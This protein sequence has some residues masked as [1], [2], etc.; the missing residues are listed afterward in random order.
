[1]KKFEEVFDYVPE[2]D[3][4]VRRDGEDKMT[5][6]VFMTKDIAEECFD[7]EVDAWTDFMDGWFCYILHEKGIDDFARYCAEEGFY[8]R[9]NLGIYKDKEYEDAVDEWDERY[10]KR[11]YLKDRVSFEE[12]FK[13]VYDTVFE[14]CA[15]DEEL[16]TIAGID[17][18]GDHPDYEEWFRETYCS[19]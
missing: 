16:C 11:W 15:F 7:K 12:W 2:T 6:T 10:L 9:E 1:M 3:S 18:S 8:V 13:V 19:Q 5:E 4:Y 14:M 17:Y